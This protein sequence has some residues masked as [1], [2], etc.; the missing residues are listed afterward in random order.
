M[1]L[2]V[3]FQWTAYEIPPRCRKARPVSHT[4]EVDV[5]ITEVAQPDAE[6]LMPV[7]LVVHTELYRESEAKHTPIYLFRGKLYKVNESRETPDEL[8]SQYFYDIVVV[9]TEDVIQSRAKEIADAYVIRDGVVCVEA[10]EPIYCVDFTFNGPFIS[11]GS[12]WNEDGL[13]DR[14]FRA[15]ELDHAI[16]AALSNEQ[17]LSEGRRQYIQNIAKE[18]C[19]IDVYLPEALKL[20]TYLNRLATNIERIVYRCLT[21]KL[22]FERETLNQTSGQNLVKEICRKVY[23][24]PE[25]QQ[26]KYLIYIS[27]VE[28]IAHKVI[29]ERF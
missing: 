29:L 28:P 2:K 21:D 3:K 18:S 26:R 4:K 14:Q 7:A 9:D 8:Q 25:F 20:P 24:N 1:K 11:I 6:T 12:A 27:D 13:T 17:G 10:P 22:S 15:D 16:Q 5:D 23:G 19:H